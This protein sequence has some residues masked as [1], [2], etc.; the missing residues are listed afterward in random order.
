MLRVVQ[1]LERRLVADGG[2]GTEDADLGAFRKGSEGA[3]KGT[4]V[5]NRR[6]DGVEEPI[7]VRNDVLVDPIDRDDAGGGKGNR[8]GLA[9]GIVGERTV[10]IEHVAEAGTVF[11]RKEVHAGERADAMGNARNGSGTGADGA[12]I[13]EVVR[14]IGR[15]GAGD[16]DVAD[17]GGI[18][19]IFLAGFYAAVRA[20]LVAGSGGAAGFLGVPEAFN[21]PY[22]AFVAGDVAGILGRTGGV[23]AGVFDFGKAGVGIDDAGMAAGILTTEGAVGGAPRA[24]GGVEVRGSGNG[25]E[26]T[27]EEFRLAGLVYGRIRRNGSLCGGRRY[28]RA[29]RG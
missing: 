16:R 5:V 21:L 19:E 10:G 6:G 9:V 4:E 8:E 28:G 24:G 1:G 14:G 29:G 2:D 23:L 3:E 20:V 7:H 15:N 27:G 25:D 11:G 17:G 26:G 13:R 18:V 12:E 22:G